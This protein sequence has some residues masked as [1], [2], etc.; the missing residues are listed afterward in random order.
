CTAPVLPFEY[1]GVADQFI[2]RLNE[3]GTGVL[4]LGGAL[5]RARA[6]RA[7][8]ERLDVAAETWRRRYADRD[9]TDESAAGIL[10]SCMQRLSRRLVPLASTAKG[11]YGHDPYGFT[12]QGSMI[13]SLFDVPAY[14]DMPDGEERWML[15]TA[16][17]R[18][19]NQVCDALD[20]CRVL[21]DDTLVLLR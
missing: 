20:D 2:A 21:I 8:A 7:A 4:G 3:L 19:R 11:A 6:F 13:P 1:V 14:A 18:A 9:S 15:E 12:P 17:V 5:D 10:H 16:L